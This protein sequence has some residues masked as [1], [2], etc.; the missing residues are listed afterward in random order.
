MLW[1]P[2]TRGERVAL[3]CGCRATVL[4]RVPLLFVYYIQ[5]AERHPACRHV[6]HLPG[7]RKIVTLESLTSGAGSEPMV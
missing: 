7:K 5:F 6:R 1:P 3:A 4:W 2:P